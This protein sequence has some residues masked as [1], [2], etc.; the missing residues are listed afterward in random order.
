MFKAFT[1]T[2]GGAD[3]GAETTI[4]TALTPGVDL[5][6]WKLL[7]VELT[8]K[9]DLVKAFAAADSDV[10]FQLTKRSLSASVARL[11]TW[12]DQDLLLSF[13]LAGINQGTAANYLIQPTDF[14]IPFRD[15]TLVYAENIYAQ[16]IS[17]ATGQ[18]LVCWGRLVYEL[19]KVNSQQALLLVAARP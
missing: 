9:P 1:V 10:T 8:L 19:T 15:E 3:T 7:G 11:V 17:T 13:N 2:Q 12:T 16:L 4:A 14:W 5:V 6:A 18:T